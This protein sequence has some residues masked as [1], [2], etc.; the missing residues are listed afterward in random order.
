MAIIN[1]Y[2]KPDLFIT[3]SCN[4]KWR[5]ITENLNQGEHAID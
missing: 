4:P 2:G 3:F 1:K 5:E